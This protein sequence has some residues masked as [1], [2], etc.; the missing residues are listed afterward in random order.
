[1]M[2]VK[3]QS[4]SCFCTLWCGPF[5]PLHVAPEQASYCA[6]C[7]AQFSSTVTFERPAGKALKICPEVA[8]ATT[9]SLRPCSIMHGTLMFAATVEFQP[10]RLTIAKRARPS[11]GPQPGPTGS[12]ALMALHSGSDIASSSWPGQPV[13][14][15]GPLHEQSGSA[16]V[17]PVALQPSP[18]KQV[19]G[20]LKLVSISARSSNPIGQVG[21]ACSPPPP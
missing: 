3:I 14:Q 12:R 7:E 16:G 10:K 17:Q 18:P 15:S 11:D 19:V 21:D 20:K 13:T 6:R 9:L 1:L 4:P 2:P 8:K 5:Q